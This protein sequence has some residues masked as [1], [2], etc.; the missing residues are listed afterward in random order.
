[1]RVCLRVHTSKGCSF[2]ILSMR[3]KRTHDNAMRSRA[4]RFAHSTRRRYHEFLAMIAVMCSEYFALAAL[5]QVLLE[6]F[7]LTMCPRARN[8]ASVRFCDAL[9]IFA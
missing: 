3:R 7:A 1:M 2:W 9:G 6:H 5:F 4:L 8:H